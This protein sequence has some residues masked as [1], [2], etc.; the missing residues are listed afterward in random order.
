MKEWVV[1]AVSERRAAFG[2]PTKC[3]RAILCNSGY[4]NSTQVSLHGK[5]YEPIA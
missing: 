4:A 5:I 1:Q 3:L 2:A